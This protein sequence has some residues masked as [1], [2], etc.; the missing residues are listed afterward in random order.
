MWHQHLKVIYGFTPKFMLKLWVDTISAADTGV[1]EGTNVSRDYTICSPSL[2][3]DNSTI[4]SVLKNQ[5]QMIRFRDNKDCY[6]QNQ[7]I[8]KYLV[9]WIILFLFKYT[10]LFN[11]IFFGNMKVVLIHFANFRNFETKREHLPS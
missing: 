2:I 11:K 1:P 9:L 4:C 10:C 8:Q 5:T 6:F 3:S 7:M